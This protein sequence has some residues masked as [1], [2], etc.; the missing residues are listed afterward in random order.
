MPLWQTASWRPGSDHV[1]G[2]PMRGLEKNYMKRGHQ[3]ERQTDIATGRPTQPRGP[4]WW[5]CYFGV[6]PWA[7]EYARTDHVPFCTSHKLNLS[8]IWKQ[9][10]FYWDS[11]FFLLLSLYVDVIKTGRGRPPWK[12]SL[13]Q[14]APT[15]FQ[16][17]HL[18][19]LWHVTR[20][21]WHVTHDFNT[22]QMTHE[23]EGMVYNV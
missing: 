16:N 10:H 5:K 23:T 19:L 6:W 12:Q 21:T 3:T 17:I 2:G 22:R 13:H 15:I 20:D 1:T 18:I 9:H 8:Q 7:W 14:L 4:S 11:W